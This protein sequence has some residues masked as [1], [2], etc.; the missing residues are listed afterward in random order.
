M[1]WSL[2]LAVL[3]LVAL[4]AACGRGGAPPGRVV[5]PDSPVNYY[6]RVHAPGSDRYQVSVAVDRLRRDSVDFILPA[7]IPG[8]Y[9]TRVP[10]S[11]ENFTARDGRNRPIPIRRIAVNAWRLYTQ[12]T[13]YVA[14]EY[15]ITRG[16]QLEPLATRVQLDLHGGYA[17]GGAVLGYFSDEADRPTTVAFDLPPSWRA[18]SS[19]RPAGPN[20]FASPSYHEIPGSLF[21]V[22]DRWSEYK[23]F[24]QGKPY[25]VAVQGAPSSFTPDS[26]LRLV[27]ETIDRG[28][29]FYG[30]APYERYLFVVSF[31][32]PEAAGMGAIGQASGT[33]IFLPPLAAN[34]MREAGLGALLLHQHLHAWFPG[35]FGPQSLRRPDYRFPPRIPDAWLIEG[36]AEYYARLL[37]ARDGVVDRRAFYDAMADVLWYW[38]EVGGGDRIDLSALSGA[39]RV[40]EARESAR[41]VAGGT[42]AVF[43]LDLLARDET[44]GVRGMDQLLMFLQRR[45]GAWGYADDQIWIEAAATQE[46]PPA[47]LSVLATRDAISID[48]NLARAGLRAVRREVRRRSLGAVLSPDAQG[49]FEVVSVERGGTAAS[50]GIRAGDKLLKINETPIAPQEVIATPFALMT[51]IEDAE[52]GSRVTFDVERGERP[53]QLT[54]TVR[55]L[56]ATRIAIVENRDASRSA[57]QVRASLFRPAF[58][59]EPAAQ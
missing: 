29:R 47:A 34:R 8:Q 41:L 36:A 43:L 42:L 38:R 56:P 17:M 49:S 13:D 46:L 7:W 57:Q 15:M 35:Q 32:S 58:A 52:T 25:Q 51:F 18:A 22:G 14:L 21:V 31:V 59:S 48:A 55:S 53:L 40:G 20:R 2:L 3:A 50:A 33:A 19:L 1:R 11:A 24:V 23:L 44:D 10:S 39:G 27:N 6:L 54:G 12:S 45:S 5:Q 9:A 16:T 4:P 37:P 28:T 26:L 30:R